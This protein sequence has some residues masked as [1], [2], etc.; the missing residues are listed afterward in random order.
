MSTEYLIGSIGSR[1]SIR[2]GR[3]IVWILISII[4]SRI[5]RSSLLLLMRLLMVWRILCLISVVV[6]RRGARRVPIRHGHWHWHS[7]IWLHWVGK[8]R[9]SSTLPWCHIWVDWGSGCG[10]MC[11]RGATGC[12][13]RSSGNTEVRWWRPS[14][15]FTSC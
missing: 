6:V 2:V 9:I 8:I 15:N 10:R 14:R 12:W 7:T 3:V 1:W 5:S 4:I 13:C 11:T